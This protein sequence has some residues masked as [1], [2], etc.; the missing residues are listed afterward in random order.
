MGS[1]R[2]TLILLLLLAIT[3]SAFSQDKLQRYVN[4]FNAQDSETVQNYVNNAQ[5]YD[6]LHKNI[7]LLECPDS[8]IEQTYYYRW[9]TFR[10]HLKQTPD[11][12]IFTEFILP[13][14]HAGRYQALS[15]AFGHH[16]M[17]GRWLRDTQYLNQYIRYWFIADAQQPTPRFHQFSSWADWAI[18]QYLTLTGDKA[19]AAKLLPYMDADYKL[20]EKERRL[21][22]GLFWQHDVKDGMEESISGGRR[23]KNM[24]PSINS[25][26]YGNAKALALI[27]RMVHQDS[28]AMAYLDTAKRLRT[29]ILDSLWDASAGFFKTRLPGGTLSDAREEIGFI[30]WYFGLPD[31]GPTYLP[32][33]QQLTDTAGFNAPWGITTAERRHPAFR[34]HGTG[35]CEWDGAIWPFATTQ[36]LKGLANLLHY[37]PDHTGMTP[38][39]FYDNLQ[40]YARSHQKN[41]QPYIGEY[42]DERTGYWLKGDNPRSSY[43]NHSGFCDLVISDLVGLHAD[44]RGKITIDPLTPWKWFRLSN[45][46]YRGHLITIS[47]DEDGSHYKK[48]FYV[49]VDNKKKI[50]SKELKTTSFYL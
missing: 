2:T 32:A 5:A 3:P 48:G 27:A 40:T 14:K 33:W 8:I 36:T 41:G 26:M 18:G 9:W 4:Q 6:W 12:F 46:P 19:F 7:P 38:A 13:V 24:R 31:N 17:E 50:H 11:G 37:Y 28:L 43:Y 34:T 47:W 39:I 25:Y 1:N 23:V 30:P 49:T 16:I 10:K 20:W 44:L 42:Q 15:C 21:P 45:I 22:N 29:L 35:G